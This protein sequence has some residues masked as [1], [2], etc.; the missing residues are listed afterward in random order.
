MT[1]TGSLE[2]FKAFLD[3]ETRRFEAYYLYQALPNGRVSKVLL[4][5]S[6]EWVFPANDQITV[7]QIRK[8]TNQ[9]IE[10]NSWQL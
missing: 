10:V 7:A 9:A 6:V 1:I 8:F 3:V 2:A 4:G 5:L